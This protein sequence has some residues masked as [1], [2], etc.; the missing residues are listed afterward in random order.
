MQHNTALPQ[1]GCSIVC[2]MQVGT[3]EVVISN[4]ADDQDD[5]LSRRMV[6]I[7]PGAGSQKANKAVTC[8]TIHLERLPEPWLASHPH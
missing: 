6:L 7:P 5:P 3:L 1:H 2:S 4:L 8:E